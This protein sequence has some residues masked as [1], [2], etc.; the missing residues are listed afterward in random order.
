[1][2]LRPRSMAVRSRP[3]TKLMPKKESLVSYHLTFGLWALGFGLLKML[4]DKCQM[5]TDQ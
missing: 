5:I 3:H 4:T 1:L 2:F